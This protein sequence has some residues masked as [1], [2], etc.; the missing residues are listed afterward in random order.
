MIYLLKSFKEFKTEKSLSII[1]GTGYSYG[2]AML[3]FHL[4]EMDDLHSKIEDRDIFT[5]G[6]KYGLEDEPHITLLYGIHSDEVSDDDVIKIL[7]SFKDKIQ[8]VELTE[9]T[10]FDNPKYEVLKFD[11]KSDIV[12]DINKELCDKLPFTNDYPEYHPHLTIAYLKPKMANK[13]IDKFQNI[14]F[15]LNPTKFVYSKPSGEKIIHPIWNND[16]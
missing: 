3:Y 14:N 4:P 8:N 12:H 7:D 6:E 9:V 1:E 15:K 11:V 2:C 5:E 10:K 16:L 13:Y